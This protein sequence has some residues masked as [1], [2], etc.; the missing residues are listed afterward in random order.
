M[1]QVFFNRIKQFFTEVNIEARKVA[2]PTRK[3]LL[4]STTVVVVTVLIVALFIS[5]VDFVFSRVI[6]LILR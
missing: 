6:G 4:A 1:K 5:L 3:E 2:W